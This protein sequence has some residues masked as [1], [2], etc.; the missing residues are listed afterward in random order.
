MP[1]N[2]QSAFWNFRKTERIPE[3]VIDVLLNRGGYRIYLQDNYSDA[4]S[5]EEDLIQLGNFSAQFLQMEDFLNELALLT[6]MA[7]EETSAK[8]RTRTR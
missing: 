1:E 3:K 5:R 2:N 7:K 6:N 8:K 4:T